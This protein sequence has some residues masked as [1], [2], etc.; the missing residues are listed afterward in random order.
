M[1]TD[2]TTD[3]NEAVTAN[4]SVPHGNL[5]TKKEF[6]Q[7]GNFPARMNKM[8]LNSGGDK[9]RKTVYNNNHTPNETP[10]PSVTNLPAVTMMN[11]SE[12]GNFNKSKRMS[13]GIMSQE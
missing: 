4:Q 3:Y 5:S 13:D 7:T 6:A 8:G 9:H 11:N 1:P 2:N 10:K 12:Y